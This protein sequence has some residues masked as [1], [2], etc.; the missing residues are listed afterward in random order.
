VQG[1]QILAYKISQLGYILEV[2]GIENVGIFYVYL[3]QLMLIWYIV[4]IVI[5]TFIWYFPPF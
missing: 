3:V 4:C 1:C 5:F 2:L